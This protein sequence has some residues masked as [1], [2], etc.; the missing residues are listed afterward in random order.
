MQ[1]WLE[2]HNGSK[3]M[4]WL[5][6]L[7]RQDTSSLMGTR[8]QHNIKAARK[9]N[10]RMKNILNIKHKTIIYKGKIEQHSKYCISLW[11]HRI[12]KQLNQVLKNIIRALNC[13]PRHAH[14]EPLMKKCKIFT[15]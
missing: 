9:D 4:G 14:E 13:K 8:N 12:T 7:P 1:N 2:Q 11:G 5:S 6:I 15:S 10:T 3:T